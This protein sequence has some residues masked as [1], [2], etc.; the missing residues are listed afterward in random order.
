MQIVHL[1][2]N[3]IEEIDV[4]LSM[5]D[6]L[7]ARVQLA[8]KIETSQH[9]IKKTNHDRNWMKEAAETLGVDLESSDDED[10]HGAKVKKARDAKMRGMKAELKHLL[11]TPIMGRGVSA[12]FITSG[13]RP[14]VED[15]L[16][17]QSEFVVGFGCGI[18]ADA[19]GF[20]S[21]NDSMIGVKKTEAGSEMLKH[22]K[23][24]RTLDEGKKGKPTA[25]GIG[26]S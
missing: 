21:V 4:E 7:K 24:K 12:K 25:A 10:N 22:K 13:S 23:R 8:R 9:K 1:E 16:A 19:P 6:E 3:C 26:S 14:I 11:S 20:L 17:G 5:L 2:E 18:V 15:L